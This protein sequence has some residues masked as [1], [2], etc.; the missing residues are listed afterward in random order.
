M[1]II[2][3]GEPGAGK[4]TQANFIKDI[5]HIPAIST[6]D[7][8]RNAA[9][10]P[11]HL[12]YVAQRAITEGELMPD[13]MIMELVKERIQAIDCIKGF[14]FIGFPRTCGQAQALKTAAIKVDHVVEIAV[15]DSS[16]VKRL[17]GRRVHPASGRS[18]H[19]EFHPPQVANQDDITHEPLVQRDDDKEEMVRRRLQVYHEE[20][21]PLIKYY[22]EW[23]NSGDSHAPTYSRISGE[24]APEE[25][26]DKIFKVLGK[27]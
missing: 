25:V 6:G 10:L 4:R 3:L 2:L 23:A 7:M 26:R 21:L 8:L 19:I 1:R 9:K 13:H 5:Y 17:S 12:G 14:V 24:Q 11:N 20:T 22:S 15:S 16:I 27:A 18:Y